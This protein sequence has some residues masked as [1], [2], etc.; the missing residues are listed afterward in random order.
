MSY[1][2]LLDCLALVMYA[3]FFQSFGGDEEE[4]DEEEIEEVPV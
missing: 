2:E 3:R 1:F 4:K